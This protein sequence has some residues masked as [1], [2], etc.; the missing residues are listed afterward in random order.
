MPYREP[1]A[2]PA[3]V[4]GFKG[5]DI[6]DTPQNCILGARAS[7]I[8][9]ASG[10]DCPGGDSRGSRA[11]LLEALSWY[12]S[13]LRKTKQK[14][15]PQRGLKSAWLRAKM[16]GWLYFFAGSTLAYFRRKR[17]TRPAVS[18]SFCL[19]VKNGMTTRADFHMD[20]AAMGGAGGKAVAA[21]AHD[22]DLIVSGMYAC[23]HGSPNLA[24]KS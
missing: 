21:R 18:T 23:L 10:A 13:C 16:R 17:S 7:S 20:I 2:H 1:F 14:P 24:A 6:D 8:E 11:A 4:A 15:P 12:S 9:E 22:A 3:M 5:Y 19:P